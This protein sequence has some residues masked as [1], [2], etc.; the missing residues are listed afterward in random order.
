MR[1][2]LLAFSLAIICSPAVADE[3]PQ[4][5]PLAPGGAIAA[6]KARARPLT[7]VVAS[8][9]VMA[10]SAVRAADGGIALVCEQKPNPHPRPLAVNRPAPEPQQ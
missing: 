5:Q 6:A 9:V 4:A 1:T 2:T 8:P 3:A 7:T 10:T